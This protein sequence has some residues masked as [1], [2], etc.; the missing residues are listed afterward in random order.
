[1]PVFET[2]DDA[3][4]RLGQVPRR[5]MDAL[6]R[7]RQS[8]A[9]MRPAR[10]H[11][12]GM[13]AA[14]LAMVATV[15]AA[16][17]PDYPAMMRAAVDQLIASQTSSGLFSYGF[18]FLADE[19]LER[20]QISPYNLIRQTGTASVLAAYYRHTG[21]AR[22]R[23]PLQ[24]MLSAF[25]RYSLPVGKARA[26]DWLER[27]RLLSVPFARWKLRAT[28]AR[29]GML[30]QPAGDGRVVSNDGRYENAFAG[31]V[32][33]ALL[34]ELVYSEAANDNQFAG[35]RAGWLRGLLDLRVPGGGFRENPASIDE[36]EYFNGEGWLALAV[37]THLHGDDAE[38]A[39]V[40]DDVDRALME[41]YS[42][43]PRAGFYHWGAMAAAQR[44]AT[45]RDPRF[46][47]FL[48][49]QAELFL[50]RMQ[51]TLKMDAN[52]CPRMEGVAATLEA[53]HRAG[54][55]DQALAKRLRSWLSGEEAKLHRLQIQPG[56]NRL[57]LGGDA[58]LRAP[59]LGDFAG[60]FRGG[61][62]DLT[63]R[64]DFA[65]HCV[66]AMVMLDRTRSQFPER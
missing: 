7:R 58:E 56:Q 64:V 6:R 13:S 5:V 62:Y 57:A 63:T 3:M 22:A 52:H 60:A 37:Y 21:D 27:T 65:Q 42:R 18:D 39:A 66:S 2:P 14:A 8:M 12:W 50:T 28:L 61:L 33:L 43:H 9:S 20:D 53:F 30:Y 11:A 45:T 46:L 48:A 51:P 15:H 25:D 1:M 55:G 23:E 49:G 10:R 34:T 44:Y 4:R 32:A 41:R 24:R 59:R 47:A 35:S 16:G 19:P 17:L 40:L 26:Q 38:T 29:L 54:M 31:T 36:S